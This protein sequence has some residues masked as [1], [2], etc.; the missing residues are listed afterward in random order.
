MLDISEI[1]RFIEEDRTSEKKLR[2]RKGLM[3]Y[4]AEHD[5][6]RY[7]VYYFD[8]NGQLKE[9]KTK[10]NERISHPFMTELVDQCVQYMLSGDSDIVRSDIPELQSRLNEYFDDDF[11]MELNDLLTYSSVE[12]FSYL[13]RYVDQSNRSRFKFADGLNVVEVPAKYTKDGKDYV[14]YYYYWKT[15]KNKK[16]HKIEVWDDE[17]VYF[18]YMVNH[19]TIKKD[20]DMPERY[21]IQYKEDDKLYYD[22]FGNVPF[23]RL[24]NNRKQFSDLKTIKDLIDD[25]DLMSCGLSNNIQD[26]AEGFYVVKGFQG[27][28]LSELT[29]AIKV[30]KQVGVGENGD[31]DIRTINIPYEARKIKLDLDEV[32]IYRFGMGFNSNQLGDGNVTNVVIK[33]RYA[34]LDLKSNKKEAMLRRTMKKLIQIVLDEINKQDKTSWDLKDVYMVFDRIVPSNE[35]DNATIAQTEANTRQTE[36]NTLLNL[37]TYLD[38]ETLMENICDVLDIDYE[39]IKDKL[40]QEEEETVEDAQATLDSEPL[41]EDTQ[42]APSEPLV[43]A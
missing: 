8:E 29:R 15:V 24:D 2:A 20:P 39:M 21:H 33:S 3:Y 25:Y 34:L 16:I 32:N 38:N 43:D 12:G 22:T 42:E 23:I 10:A 11:K 26:F 17:K 19:T 5:I 41:E 18:Y 6:K 7:K 37:A 9:D 31:V 35:V 30:K 28:D 1:K 40:P 14:I 13:Y 4:E 36:I 27:H